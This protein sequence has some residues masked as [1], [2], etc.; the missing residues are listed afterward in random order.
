[1][2]L[3][4][5]HAH[6]SHLYTY[7]CIMA[8]RLSITDAQVWDRLERCYGK[9]TLSNART[10]P[11]QHTTYSE[12]LLSERMR[13]KLNHERRPT[14]TA[15]NLSCH[16]HRSTGTDRP[17]RPPGFMDW[18]DVRRTKQTFLSPLLLPTLPLPP[19]PRQTHFCAEE[20]I[21]IEGRHSSL[22]E[23]LAQRPAEEVT[24][25]FTDIVALLERRGIGN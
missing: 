8:R 11:P 18:A 21:T 1:M 12:G 9:R 25:F 24:A 16:S 15:N 5:A 13:A 2:L 22:A 7:A 14:R 3:L 4:H 20:A 17:S 6:K 10:T 19:I 23:F